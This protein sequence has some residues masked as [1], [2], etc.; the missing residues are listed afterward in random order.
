MNI[1]IRISKASLNPHQSS[2]STLPRFF[3]ITLSNL[4]FFIEC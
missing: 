2:S 4:T 3:H 1:L